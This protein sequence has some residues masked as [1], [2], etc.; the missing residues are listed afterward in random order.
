MANSI[1][2]DIT[3]AITDNC[4]ARCRMCNIWQK[5]QN[6]NFS[7]ELIP[8]LNQEIRYI[9]LTGGEPFLRAD[10]PELVGLIHNQCPKAQIIISSNGFNAE[11]I[12]KTAQKIIEVYPKIGVRISLD[13]TENTHEYIRG[14]KGLF[15]EATKTLVGLKDIGV[16]NLG[17]G[18]TIMD[19]NASE[20]NQVYELAEKL[21]IQFSISAVQNSEI[22]FSKDSN[23]I[24]RQTMINQELDLI[25]KKQLRKWNLKSWLRAYFVFGLKYNLNTGQRLLPSGAGIDSCFIDPQGKVYPSNLVNQVLGNLSEKKLEKIW[26]DLGEKREKIKSVLE[27][28]PWTI[29]TMRGSLKKHWFKILSWVVIEKI[30]STNFQ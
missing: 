30:K 3:L 11:H 7:K 13:G 15:D 8:N 19:E 5:S 10:L 16:K 12:I 1:I 25:I 24:S 23:K 17:I 20:I 29:C 28:E 27:N 22:Y 2:K 18:F 4:N 21:G 6:F 26:I 9:N 14:V